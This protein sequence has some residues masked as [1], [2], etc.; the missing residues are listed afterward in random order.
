MQS[1]DRV[2]E[3][4]VDQQ[5]QRFW[6]T[7]AFF[8]PVPSLLESCHGAKGPG[9]RNKIVHPH[10]LQTLPRLLSQ[11]CVLREKERKKMKEK[12]NRKA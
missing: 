1:S 6:S 11:E 8:T 9:R 12:E 7:E 2:Q 10:Q 4:D 3:T 5:G